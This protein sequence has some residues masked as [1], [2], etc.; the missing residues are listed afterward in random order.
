M[1]YKLFFTHFFTLTLFIISFGQQS[2][3][4]NLELFSNNPMLDKKLDS[5]FSSFNNKNSPGFA[6]TVIQN[7][8]VIAKK[9]YGMASI[10]LQ[11][12]FTHNTVVRL[13]YSEGRE[14]I[15]IAAA[16]MEQDRIIS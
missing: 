11:V 14:F 1:N 12:P 2:V 8:K 10:E 5:L 4:S 3:K 9:D 7:E 15:S 6:V 13:P 16:L